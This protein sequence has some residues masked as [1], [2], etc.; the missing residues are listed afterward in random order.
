GLTV[1]PLLARLG[2]VIGRRVEAV[3]EL[4]EDEVE[5]QVVII[6]AGRVGRL[7]ARMLENHGKPYIAMDSNSDLVA[8]AKRTGIR[9]TFG[10]A[11]HAAALDRL[12]I[13]KALA[14]V[15][16]MDEP[17]LAQRLVVRLRSDY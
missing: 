7:V 12:G 3:P 13:E 6:G 1:T 4:P 15:L 10:D 16:T 17:V 2:R 5:P 14:V 8:G 11:A 9:A